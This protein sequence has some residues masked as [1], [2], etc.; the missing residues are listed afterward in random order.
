ML[1]A[2]EV[3]NRL[4]GI[5]AN[6]N[7]SAASFATKIGVQ[8]S[9]ISHILSGRNK[10]SLDF[11][12]KVY[13]SFDEVAL[14]WLILGTTTSL[15]REVQDLDLFKSETINREMLDKTKSEAL[16]ENN[17]N[18]PTITSKSEIALKEIVHFYEDGTFER[19]K[20][21]T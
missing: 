19:F 16:T 8:R 6:H 5:M 21:K 4:E 11:L 3:I 13:E 14:E 17:I 2:S 1:N 7:L 15:P 9:A 18:S 12:M 10:P 20:P